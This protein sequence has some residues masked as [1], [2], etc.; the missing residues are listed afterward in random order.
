MD[1]FSK[2]KIGFFKD[3]AESFLDLYVVIVVVEEVKCVM[4]DLFLELCCKFGMLCFGYIIVGG[5]GGGEWFIEV[6]MDRSCS[7]TWIKVSSN[8]SKKVVCYYLL[9]VMEVVVVLECVNE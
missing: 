6:F 8:K 1:K 3:D 2:T 5:V 4:D 9:E 7:T